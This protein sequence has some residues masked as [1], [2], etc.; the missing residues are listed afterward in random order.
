MPG[1]D[2]G[3]RLQRF[4]AED[5]GIVPAQ[6]NTVALGTNFWSD[7]SWVNSGRFLSCLPLTRGRLDGKTISERIIAETTARGEID[8]LHRDFE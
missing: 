1:Y 7:G 3:S 2:N 8:R 5:R 4:R 6:G